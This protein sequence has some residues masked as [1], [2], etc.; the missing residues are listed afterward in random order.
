MAYL[1]V[2]ARRERKSLSEHRGPGVDGLPG[3]S[4]CRLDYYAISLVSRDVC[5][6]DCSVGVRNP[7]VVAASSSTGARHRDESGM[8]SAYHVPVVWLRLPLSLLSAF[9]VERK[10]RQLV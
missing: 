6:E 2:R 10:Q 4:E 8:A 3:E 1:R 5:P 7:D 9:S